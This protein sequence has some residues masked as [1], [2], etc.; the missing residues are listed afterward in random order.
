MEGASQP[1]D[2]R[3]VRL[4]GKLLAE[5]GIGPRD[6]RIRVAFGRCQREDKPDPQPR[7]ITVCGGL[8]PQVES[9]GYP[10]SSVVSRLPIGTR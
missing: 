8:F 5:V 6:G 9:T 2:H 4:T 7:K 3:T 1:G 10:R